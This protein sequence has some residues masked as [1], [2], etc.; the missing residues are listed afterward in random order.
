VLTLEQ[1]QQQQQAQQAQRMEDKVIMLWRE[2]QYHAELLIWCQLGQEV[3]VCHFA[4][5]ANNIPP[6]SCMDKA[7]SACLASSFGGK[8]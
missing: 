3:D 5:V 1:Q 8:A 4:I 6:Q 7:M 2:G